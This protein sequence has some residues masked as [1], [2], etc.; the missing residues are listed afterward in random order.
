MHTLSG[1]DPKPGRNG[2]ATRRLEVVAML[3]NQRAVE[4]T[5]KVSILDRQY[6]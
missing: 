2:L 6:K 3:H 4:G 5:H 1:E